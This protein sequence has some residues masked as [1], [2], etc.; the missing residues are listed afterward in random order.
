MPATGGEGVLLAA[1]GASAGYALYVQTGRLVYH[2]NWFDRERT[3]LV[4]NI[5]LPTGKSTVM[6]EFA[7]D[8]GGLG[9]GGE[10]V[11]GID[12]KEVGRARIE[13]TVAGRF[14]IDTFGVGSDTGSP[15]TNTYKA[16]FPFTGTIERVDIVLGPR[17]LSPE[18]EAKLHE[19]YTAFVGTHE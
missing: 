6:M 4:S 10:A 13:H 18:D 12:G 17:N 8:G 2:Y 7:Y 3:N 9:K 16:S 15:V 14:G 1:G 5:P 19:M 11:I